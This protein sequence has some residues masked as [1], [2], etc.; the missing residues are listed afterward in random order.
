NA[1]RNTRF[2]ITVG[3]L[4]P[5]GAHASYSNTGAPLLVSAYSNGTSGAI[6]TTDLVGNDG[7]AS[8]DYTFGFGGTSAAAPMV[9]GVVA[10]MLSA[11]PAL[12]Y[13]DVQRI[14][15][16]TARKNDPA[17]LGWVQNGAGLWVN[18]KY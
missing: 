13:R 18:Y 9:S 15:A 5:S 14:L 1:Y 10:L 2:G 3:A 6:T 16:T 7:F 4:D 17:D 11:N 8:G 12:S